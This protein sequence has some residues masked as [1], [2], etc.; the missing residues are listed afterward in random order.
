MQSANKTLEAVCSHEQPNN[1]HF[2]I[3]EMNA[4]PYS[5]NNIYDFFLQ[6]RRENSLNAIRCS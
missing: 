3:L 5:Y 4:S 2:S 6:I 1:L